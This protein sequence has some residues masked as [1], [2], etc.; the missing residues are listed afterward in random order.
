MMDFE[1]LKTFAFTRFNSKT[2]RSLA[3]AC[4]A[5]SIICLLC[6]PLT[7]TAQSQLGADIDGEAAT[8][9]SGGSVVLSADG[10]R[11]AV[12]ARLNDGNGFDSGQVRVFQWIDSAWVQLG[13]DINGE[14]IYDE[15]GGA[16]ALSAEGKRLAIGSTLNDG[17]GPDSGQVRVFQWDGAS[18]V[19][20]GDDIDGEAA[21]DRFGGSVSLS[22]DGQR[23]AVGARFNDGNGLDSGHVRVFQWNGVTWEQIGP[24]IDGKAAYDEFG[25]SV[26]LSSYGERLA[27]GADRNDDNGID[28]GQVRVYQWFV[29]FWLQLGDDINGEAF[30]DYSGNS[31][32]LSSD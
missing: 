30:G 11:L 17:N 31:V 5:L 24:D 2:S 13:E 26:S 6:L 28:S 21:N 32:S 14:A 10:K 8:D 16:V 12:G 3:T 9:E 1:Q 27:I 4:L 25:G 7:V 19:K 18:W 20:L 29:G 23:L 22:S 15:S